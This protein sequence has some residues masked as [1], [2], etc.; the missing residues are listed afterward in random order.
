MKFSRK[1]VICT[2]LDHKIYHCIQKELKTQ[3]VL[4]KKPTKISKHYIVEWTD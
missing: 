2:F 1:I 4:E 3:E